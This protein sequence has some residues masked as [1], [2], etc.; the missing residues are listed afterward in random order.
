[1][2]D[3]VGFKEREERLSKM[4]NRLLY[5]DRRIENTV[6]K[7]IDDVKVRG[8]EALRFY[9]KKFDGVKIGDFKVEH[10]EIQ[11]AYYSVRDDLVRVLEE[12]YATVFWY[13]RYQI[14]RSWFVEHRGV[15]MGQRVTPIEKVG[16]Y[17]PGGGSVYP[18]TVIMAAVPAQMAEVKDI[19]VVSPPNRKGKVSPLVLAACYIV[20][21]SN[22]Y[23]I[24]G[25]QAIAAL[26]YGTETVPRVDKIVGPGN[27]YVSVAKRMVFGDV[28][29][30]MIAG[31]SEI[32]VISDG[33]VEPEIV[34]SDI[35]AQAEHDEMAVPILITTDRKFAVRVRSRIEKI[36]PSLPKRRII[37][38]S[39]KNFGAIFLARDMEDAA[40]IVNKIAP[41]HV[42]ILVSEPFEILP[43]IKNAG[44]IFIGKFSPVA[45]GDYMVGPSHILP[46]GS[47]ARFGSVLSVDDFIKRTSIVI[48]TE[49]ML[50]KDRKSIK[51]I[52]EAEKLHAHSLSVES[53]FRK[54][55]EEENGSKWKDKS[56]SR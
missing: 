55:K 45:A 16:I 33:S 44:A 31:P 51:V 3:I 48:Y 41:E 10:N 13:H 30:D 47:S 9:T 17:A 12:I 20:G 2:L 5:V 27:I 52:A 24:G 11:D 29:I 32:V 46:T 22:V 8:D 25:A 19:Y 50:N 15:M 34:A 4:E 40:D 1:M 39:L 43:M 6:R 35:I 53:R 21:I 49:K 7:V 36:V 42:E 18:S 38:T 23:A 26:A 56:S 54:K 14:P 37:R 28:G